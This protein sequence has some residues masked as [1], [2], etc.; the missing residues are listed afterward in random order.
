MKKLVTSAL[1]ALAFAAAAS[2]QDAVIHARQVMA[3]PGE[4]YITQQTILVEG[5]RKEA[6]D[7][8]K[9]LVTVNNG[10]VAAIHALWS[11]D[12]LGLLDD[13]PGAPK[14]N[15]IVRNI[16][17]GGTWK[18]IE[19]IG[20]PLVVFED[21]WVDQEPGFIDAARFN[22]QLRDDAPALRT[23][24]KR[25]PIEQIGLLPRSER[26]APPTRP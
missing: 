17:V 16:S 4:G 26:S 23:G 2:A 22:F 9:R 25:I 18:N 7:A 19:K 11:L 3:V 20:E 8:L 12:G 13:E 14:G 6:R 21:N 15:R 5:G 1:G 24:F 10:A